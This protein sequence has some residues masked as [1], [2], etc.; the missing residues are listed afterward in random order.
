MTVGVSTGL[1]T[2][3]GIGVSGSFG[4]TGSDKTCDAPTLFG[5]GILLAS[6]LVSLDVTTGFVDT[7]SIGI[8][9]NFGATGSDKTCAAPTLF[10]L[11]MLSTCV[12]RS[13]TSLIGATL[14]TTS[15]RVILFNVLSNVYETIVSV[16][17]TVPGLLVRVSPNGSVGSSS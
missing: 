13:L 9:G 10:G 3:D 12:P 17:P 6:E 11:G 7:L 4:T 14:L 15:E 2:V 8:S 1:V 16:Y 5:L